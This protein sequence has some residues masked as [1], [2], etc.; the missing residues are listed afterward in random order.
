MKYELKEFNQI[1][2]LLEVVEIL[3]G[4]AFALTFPSQ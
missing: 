1:G 2:L 4:T 3:G